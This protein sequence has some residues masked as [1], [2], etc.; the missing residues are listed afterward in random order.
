MV[1]AEEKRDDPSPKAIAAATTDCSLASARPLT[2]ESLPRDSI[3]TAKFVANVVNDLGDD[4]MGYSA[5]LIGRGGTTIAAAK[6]GWAR[7]ACEAEGELRFNHNT[8]TAWGSVT[9]VLTTALAIDKVER[10]SQSLEEPMWEN[11]PADW[12]AESI[13]D[14]SPHQAVTIRHLLSHRSGFATNSPLT[15]RER[16]TSATL[17]KPIGTRD[18]SNANFAIF[19]RMGRFFREGY[20]DDM[21]AS[22]SPGE[23][24]KE[25]FLET[26]GLSI[27]QDTFQNRIADKLGIAFG[28]NRPEHAGANFSRYYTWPNATNGY[29]I[30]PVD[31]P[32]CSTGG[33]MMS[34]RDMATF[35]HAL[36]RTDEIISHENYENE[37]AVPGKERLGWDYAIS[38]PGGMMYGKNGARG[39]SRFKGNSYIPGNPSG[40]SYS[41]IVAYPNGTMALITANSPRPSTAPRFR[42]ILEDAYEASVTP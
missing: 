7:T 31:T 25:D 34:P 28:C 38:V 27:Y 8:Q 29:M 2:I 17:E 35:L 39:F 18:Y 21:E 36:T 33:V 11:L 22:Y 32:G 19:Q 16:A 15:L 30:N 37:M 10:S 41:E 42:R 6:Y 20:F 12:R 5:M 9:K 4:Y 14:N 1:G 24:T 13:A 23:I 26:V 3:D 40:G